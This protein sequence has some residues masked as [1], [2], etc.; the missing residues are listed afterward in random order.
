VDA[1]T[2]HKL[3]MDFRELERDHAVLLDSMKAIEDQMKKQSRDMTDLQAA[4]AEA[5]AQL[6]ST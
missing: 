4:L 2:Y 3:R 5:R 1:E 6:K